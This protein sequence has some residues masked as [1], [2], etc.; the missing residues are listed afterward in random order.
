MAETSPHGGESSPKTAIPNG[1]NRIKTRPLSKLT[2]F[3]GMRK[4][5]KIPLWLK[6]NVVKDLDPAVLD[7][8]PNNEAL[9]KKGLTREMYKVRKH[10]TG[11]HKLGERKHISKLPKGSKS[12]SHGL[13]PKSGIRLIHPRPHSFVDLKEFLGS[14]RS[15]F[16]AA[17]EVVNS[18]LTCFIHEVMEVLQKNNSMSP[19]ELQMIEGLLILAKQ[20]LGMNSLEFR[21]NCEIIVQDLTLKRQ[22]NQTGDMKWLFTRMLF[23]LTR[24]TRLLH[25]EKDSEPID[26][27]SFLKIKECLKRVPSCE[28]NWFMNTESADSDLDNAPNLRS[29]A[30]DSL[31]EKNQSDILQCESCWGADVPLNESVENVLKDVMVAEKIPS[32][33]SHTEDLSDRIQQ[34]HEVDEDNLGGSVKNSDSGLLTEPNPSVDELD[35]VICRICEELVPSAQLEPHSYICAYA[36]KCDITCSNLDERL[37]RH[38]EVLEQILDSLNLTVSATYDIPEGSISRTNNSIVP[39]GY[40]PK[41]SDWQGKGAE[42]MF[43]DIHEMD[44]AYIEDTHLTTFSGIRGQSGFKISHGPPSSAES[45]TSA[46][47]ANTP[48]SGSFD[49]SW[50]EHQNPSELEDVQ[51]MTDLVDIARC[52]ADA[53]PS[54]ERFHECLLACL[55]DLQDILQHSKHKALLIETFG[56]RIENLLREK[57]MLAC[58]LVDSRSVKSDSGMSPDNTSQSSRMSTPKHKDRTSIDDFEIIKPISKGAYGKVFLAR[59][60]TTGDLFAI[61]VLKKLDMLRK[62]DIERIVAERNILIR[63]RNPFVV[64]FFYS[65]TSKENLYLVMEYLNGGDLYSLVRNVGC[66]EEDVARV[67]IAELVLALEYLHSLEI[68]HRDVKPDNILIAHD[69]HIKLTDFGLSKIGLMNRTNDLSGYETNE[70]APLKANNENSKKGAE[71]RSQQSAV[72]TPDYL[73]PEFLLGSKHGY[74]ADWWSVGIIL[75]EL[76]TGIPPFTGEHVEIIF[77]NI[78]NRKI[79]WPPVPKD[80]SSEAQDLIDRLLLLD[81][82]QRL[83]AQGSSEVKAHPFFRGI[84][85]ES[86]AL[87]KAAFVPHLDSVDDT[88]YFVSRFTDSFTARDNDQN[89]SDSDSDTTDSFLNSEGCEVNVLP[90]LDSI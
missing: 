5:K 83:G 40:S 53:D 6:S 31:E 63:V 23:I 68:V 87:Q 56:C 35:L 11:K 50:I 10:H 19:L 45:M 38:A 14:L 67:Y 69:G 64:R 4:E 66:L 48:R 24:C 20:C 62:N 51:Q 55:E 8:D 54:E 80:M 13:G 78:L 36:D 82:N 76:I 70:Y 27:K 75:Y 90:D 28:M 42:G 37:Q 59:K 15:R 22:Q 81:P 30:K 86:L 32:E 33:A 1:L 34:F 88:S 9:D 79:P 60:R 57:Y 18:E 49:F 72:G 71:D 16:S 77:D 74:A 21:S 43:D 26:E 47:S 12:F 65:F 89:T 58:E 2:T 61:K 29:G 52:V 73:A 39:E 46:S 3:K 41:I 85:W 25:F 84:N 17:K 44:T 7:A